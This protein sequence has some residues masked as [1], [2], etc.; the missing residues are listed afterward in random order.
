MAICSLRRIRNISMMR[1]DAPIML[2][3]LAALSVE[4]QKYF[5]TSMSMDCWMVLSVLN[6]LTS[7]MRI[8]VKGSFSLR[9]CFNAER[10]ST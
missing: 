6:T 8:R 1:L 7:I 9:T 10:L 5:F 2:T 3:G 4:T